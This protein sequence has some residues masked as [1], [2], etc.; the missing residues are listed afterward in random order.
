M[1]KQPQTNNKAK[2][3]QKYLKGREYAS[4]RIFPQRLP[5]FQAIFCLIDR[6]M[7]NNLKM[8]KLGGQTGSIKGKHL[9]IRKLVTVLS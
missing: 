3:D 8:I 1:S 2:R 4:I 5:G 7:E 6:H 9:E